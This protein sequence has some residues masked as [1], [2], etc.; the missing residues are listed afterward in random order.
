MIE[1]ARS[2][3]PDSVFCLILLEKCLE[4]G[5]VSRCLEDSDIISFTDII[6]DISKSFSV[7]SNL[8]ATVFIL[9]LVFYISIA[10]FWPRQ[11]ISFQPRDVCAIQAFL[12]G[13]LVRHRNEL[14][15]RRR[16]V[17]VIQAFGRG[18][19][20]RHQNELGLRKQTIGVLQVQA[21]MRGRLVRQQ[22]AVQLRAE[23]VLQALIRGYFA[24]R[25]VARLHA[26]RRGIRQHEAAVALRG[27]V[28][29]QALIRGHFVCCH[30]AR[31]QS[32]AKTVQLL[33]FC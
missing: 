15:L 12:R 2:R 26:V 19:Y 11:T 10:Q 6:L 20:V 31:L 18:W 17:D 32:A 14:G 28:V 30:M 13:T 8:S 1:I 3:T 16:A 7:F 9:L 29:L 25:H 27:T 4:Q 21:L 5:L 22:L 24:R 33:S 23:L